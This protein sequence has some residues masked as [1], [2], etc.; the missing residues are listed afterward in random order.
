MLQRYYLRI[1]NK[2]YI[3]L[4]IKYFNFQYIQYNI[5]KKYLLFYVLIKNAHVSIFQFIFIILIFFISPFYV[6]IKNVHVNIFQFIFI[7]LIN[8]FFSPS[9]S[10]SRFTGNL[11][12]KFLLFS[13]PIFGS[14]D[15]LN[16]PGVHWTN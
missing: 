9:V 3:F 6:F 5:L 13:L 4:K 7:I 15:R 14:L 16:W 1:S 10:D 8:F 12:R 2:K 11:S